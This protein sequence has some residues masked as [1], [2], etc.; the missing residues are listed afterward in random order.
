MWK[1]E[2]LVHRAQL[3]P[4]S[5]M[6]PGMAAK[7]LCVRP[8]PWLG[9]HGPCVSV[10]APGM[11]VV[12]QKWCERVGGYA[13]SRDETCRPPCCPGGGRARPPRGSSRFLHK[14]SCPPR[15]E[16]VCYFSCVALSLVCNVHVLCDGGSWSR[17][18]E[19]LVFCRQLVKCRRLWPSLVLFQVMAI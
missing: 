6:A 18:L 15:L 16:S 14:S 7:A 12:F 11:T 3:P 10:L 2:T 17:T 19:N 8:G 9:C 1:N 5:T 13:Q 4:V